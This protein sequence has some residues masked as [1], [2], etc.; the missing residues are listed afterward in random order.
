M[1]KNMKIGERGQITIPKE[2][3]DQFERKKLNLAKWR[4]KCARSLAEL[5]YSSVDQFI[6]DVRGL[7]K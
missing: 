3:R 5:G 6:E 7:L 4:G 2:I 1:L